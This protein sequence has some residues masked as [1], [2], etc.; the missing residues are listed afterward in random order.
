[1]D[2]V[3]YGALRPQS[4][5]VIALSIDYLLK[6]ID[7]VTRSIDGELVTAVVYLAISQ[8]NLRSVLGRPDQPLRYAAFDAN[9]D[10]TVRQPVSVLAIARELDLPYETTRRHV[11]KLQARGLC[12][13]V[14]DGGVMIP[15]GVSSRGNAE[16]AMNEICALTYRYIADLAAIGVTAPAR[17]NAAAPDLR[18]IASREAAYYVLNLMK[19]A[20][21]T[22]GLNLTTA[23]LLLGIIRANAL[24]LLDDEERRKAHADGAFGLDVIVPDD[25]RRPITTYALAGQIDMPYET[26]R[27][28]VGWLVDAGFCERRGKGLIVPAR[29]LVRPE[30]L[31]SIRL[32]WDETLRFLSVMGRLGIGPAQAR[33]GLAQA[34]RSLAP[35]EAPQALPD[36]EA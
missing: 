31:E 17:R 24:H 33:K 1:M 27:R 15:D 8:A 29:A 30:L 14:D 9:P 18:R 22:V 32:N 2:D 12:Q 5:Q 28:Q 25:L 20:R 34:R 4:R 19:L 6:T 36:A 13:R 10:D 3:E 35:R 16:Q 21:M 26:A 23:V 11:G 7:V